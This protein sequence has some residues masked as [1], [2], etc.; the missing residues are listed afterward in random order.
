MMAD[1][2]CEMLL[3]WFDSGEVQS[4][5]GIP[6]SLSVGQVIWSPDN[7]GLAQYLVFVGWSGGKRKLGIKY[8]SNRPCAIYAIKFTDVSSS[9]SDK[10][11]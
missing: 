4:I 11:K 3:F 6:R 9:G 7:K 2:Y 10:S 5:K 1:T 8:C